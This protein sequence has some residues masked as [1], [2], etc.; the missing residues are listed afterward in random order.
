MYSEYYN[1]RLYV[2]AKEFVKSEF[3]KMNSKKIDEKDALDSEKIAS[4]EIDGQLPGSSHLGDCSFDDEDYYYLLHV[5]G[6]LLLLFYCYNTVSS[7]IL[8][9]I[10]S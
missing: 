4:D 1:F 8:V 5:L 3:K 6:R 2:F 9:K 10:F 7:S